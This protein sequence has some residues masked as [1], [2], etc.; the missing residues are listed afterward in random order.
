M[1]VSEDDQ[2]PM[3]LPKQVRSPGTQGVNRGPGVGEIG[4]AGV[5]SCVPVTT[6]PLVLATAND[7]QVSG[8]CRPLGGE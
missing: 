4:Q 6:H 7:S 2:G 1:T 8:V 3:T 5:G